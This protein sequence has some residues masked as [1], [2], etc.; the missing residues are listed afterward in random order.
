MSGNCMLN[1]DT[2]SHWLESIKRSPTC[3][4]E[5]KG[6]SLVQRIR[7]KDMSFDLDFPLPLVV[8]YSDS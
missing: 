7:V 6:V 8:H 1:F 4:W 5:N 3:Q 2:V